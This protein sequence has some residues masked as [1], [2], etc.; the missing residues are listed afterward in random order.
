[1]QINDVSLFLMK[2]ILKTIA[3]K[4]S[5]TLDAAIISEAEQYVHLEIT[6][7]KDYATV[8]CYSQNVN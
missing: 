7:E 3:S 4:D 8:Q 2:V 6:C 5:G 1:M